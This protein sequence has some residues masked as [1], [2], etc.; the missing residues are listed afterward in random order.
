MILPPLYLLRHGQTRWNLEGRLQ[1]H[2]DS[3]LTDLGRAQ[4][5]AQRAILAGL[6]LPK[7]VTAFASP[8]GRARSTAAIALRDREPPKLDARLREIGAGAWEGKLRSETQ[9]GLAA[10]EKLPFEMFADAPGGE[11]LDG[12]EA[13]LRA[14]LSDL[15]GPAILVSHGVAISVLRGL[16]LGLDRS[17]MAAMGNPQG[18][19][20]EIADGVETLHT[21]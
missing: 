2:L 21:A 10:T 5:E 3:D 11:G 8:L 1:G 4:A 9:P 12:L 13:R 19:V 15:S 6:D 20:I 16:A 17:A 18:V 14:F 7:T